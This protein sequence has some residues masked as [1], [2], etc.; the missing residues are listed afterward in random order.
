MPTGD[1]ARAR[2]RPGVA[3]ARR[4]HMVCRVAAGAALRAARR[5][6]GAAGRGAHT[7]GAAANVPGEQRAAVDAARPPQPRVLLQRARLGIHLPALHAAARPAVHRLSA[8]IPAQWRERAERASARPCSLGG[9]AVLPAQRAV[10]PRR[11]HRPYHDQAAARWPA[12]AAHRLQHARRA[13]LRRRAARARRA[14]GGG[15][16]RAAAGGEQGRG[17]ALKSGE[18]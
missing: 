10:H 9:S 7:D 2:G 8:A 6:G 14:T 18:P 16:A 11:D 1:L 13:P 3:H 4:A 15:A 17:L 12:D 5:G